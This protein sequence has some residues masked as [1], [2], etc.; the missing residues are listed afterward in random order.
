M[1]AFPDLRPAFPHTAEF[2]VNGK[3]TLHDIDFQPSC[4][5][6]SV[7]EARIL[8]QCARDFPGTWCEIGSHTGWSGAHIARGLRPP[9]EWS[10][11][12]VAIEP[13]FVYL[14]FFERARD[15]WQRAE[16]DDVIFP[17]AARSQDYFAGCVETFA[18][19]F[20]DGDHSPGEPLKD[21]RMVLPRLAERAVVVFHDGSGQPVH[22]AAAFM[23]AQ[24][25]TVHVYPSMATLTVCW[26]GEWEPPEMESA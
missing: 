13:Q 5:Y 8:W 3:P 19:V 23:G 11:K 24:G 15:N 12:L 4:G 17:V 25:F 22:E 26:R 7:D 9:D 10:G 1:T 14:S 21:A 16:V 18:G 20:V 6:V 2:I